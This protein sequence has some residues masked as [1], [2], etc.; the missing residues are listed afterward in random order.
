L[1]GKITLAHR[2]RLKSRG[3]NNLEEKINKLLQL[4]Q[5]AKHCVAFTGAGISTESGIPDFRSS[6][7]GLWEK[8][9]PM[10]ALSTRALNRNPQIL[11]Q[12]CLSMYEAAEA[13]QPNQAHLVL[14]KLEEKGF[15]K[16]LI[17]QNIDNLHQRAGSK[18]VLEIHGTL[19]RAVCRRC[20]YEEGMDSVSKKVRENKEMPPTC[21]CGGI[22]K[23]D[24]TLF[25][26]SLPYDFTLAQKE[27]S[28]ADLM[29]VIGSS[30]VVSPANYLPTLCP[31]IIIINKGSTYCDKDAQVV[32]HAKAGEVMQVLGEKLAL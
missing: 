17:T 3:G 24:I 1:A 28:Q 23:P 21:Q 16:T 12:V 30:L 26:E 29:L 11:Y 22:L 25:G 2:I 20:G 15:L 31:N 32:L 19:Q 7:V 5:K 6:D 18:N 4:I 13:A 8:I 10:E 9:D 27:A 14:A